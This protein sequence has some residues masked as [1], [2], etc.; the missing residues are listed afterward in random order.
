MKVAV[1]GATGMVGQV[2]L[3][4]LA[5]RDFPITEL[6][7]VASEKSVG[8]KVTYKDKEYTI[9]SLADA[10][11]AKPEIAI[12][13]AGGGTSL[14]WAPK[15]AENGTTV[16]DNSSAWRMDPTKKLV[17]PEINA[18]EL[19]KEDK[20]IANPNC[21]T[22]QL[23]M[24]LKPLHDKYTI[25]R[26]V[27][28]TYQSITGT[29]VKAVQ[30]LENEYEDKEG[31]MAY[32]YPIHRNALPHCDVFQDNGYTKEEMKLTNETKKILGDDSVS[33]T[34]TAIRIPVVGGHSESV[35]LEFENDFEESEVRKILN[36]FPGVT[37][38]D[39]PDTNTYPMPIYAEGKNDVFVGRIRRDYS[40]PNSLNLW[41]VADNLR[42]GAATNAVQIAE[43]LIE[44][45]L[46]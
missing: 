40:Q 20:I 7:P 3:K 30:Q 43:Y 15:F 46:V 25:K 5:E 28:S 12:F 22:I 1:V 34:A 45:K 35:N 18:S 42:K 23:L 39:N 29:G 33:V 36:D 11:A 6:L 37:V 26:A 31:E 32:P 13:S 44:N 4:V 27:V 41:V 2:M 24:A 8:K 9:I 10:V 17:I 16:V 21:S 14:E 19:T 38:Q